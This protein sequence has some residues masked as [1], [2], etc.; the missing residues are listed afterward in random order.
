[1][2]DSPGGSGDAEVSKNTEVSA[3]IELNLGKNGAVMEEDQCD[4]VSLK[5]L[6]DMVAKCCYDHYLSLPKTG[7]PKVGTE[8][9]ALSGIVM[10]N[11]QD[12]VK[13]CW[14]EV[15]S[16][17]TGTK[18][19]GH[20]AMSPMGD[21]LNDSHAEV[22]ARRGFLRYLYFELLSVF[23]S[24]AS[25]VISPP[26]N[27]GKCR[28]KD[29]IKFH[30]YTS[31]TPCGD[32]SIIPK[33]MTSDDSVG[34]PLSKIEIDSTILSDGIRVVGIESCGVAPIL[35]QTGMSGE[36]MNGGDM[37]KLKLIQDENIPIHHSSSPDREPSLTHPATSLMGKKRKLSEM[38][39]GKMAFK[40][41]RYPGYN[42]ED[43]HRTGAKCV[44]STDMSDPHLPGAQY[45][46]LGAIRYKPGRGEQTHSVSCSDKLARWCS[47]GIEGALLSQFFSAP[48]GISSI[49]VGGGCPYSKEALH[50]AIIDRVHLPKEDDFRVLH[51]PPVIVQSSL[52]FIHGR[53]S[54]EGL[55]AQ[56][57]PCPSSIVWSRVGKN[58]FEVA[59][60]GRKQGVT[61]KALGTAA[62]R[63]KICKK[64]ILNLYF[65]V[66]KAKY[67]HLSER[68]VVSEGMAYFNLKNLGQGYYKAWEVMRQSSFQSWPRKCKSLIEFT[69]NS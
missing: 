6:G 34:M 48:I 28:I 35:D 26:G 21:V 14:L 41:C 61:K 39:E 36:T 20:S 8:W 51:Q 17:G 54:S 9:T 15:V 45:H 67:N 11:L 29:G 52:P 25:H 66:Q 59:V 30:F 64:E 40:K 68:T 69:I 27:D 37:D 50:R 18:C 49:V 62:G 31:H 24:R 5:Q 43:V 16:L 55:L 53:Y 32:A 46:V 10:E 47:V 23:N 38:S 2:G 63:L 22:M 12:N 13:D 58:A 56:L 1:M 65:D 44:P 33:G 57:K 7:K 42:A 60:N 19:L 4:N 3:N